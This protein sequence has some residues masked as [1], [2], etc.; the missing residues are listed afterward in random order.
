MFQTILLVHTGFIITRFI[1]SSLHIFLKVRINIPEI[2]NRRLHQKY[3]CG[4][5]WPLGGLPTRYTSIFTQLAL[6][7]C[8]L[9]HTY[10]STSVLTHPQSHTHTHM[11]NDSTYLRQH[12]TNCK[13]EKKH[14]PN[15]DIVR[16][17]NY[18]SQLRHNV[19]SFIYLQLPLVFKP[20]L[21]GPRENKK[22]MHY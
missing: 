13:E 12:S 9:Q 5:K 19:V 11:E 22:C 20:C 2:T 1:P 16:S 15:W 3:A 8:S 7:S 18:Q 14:F 21:L 6:G 17:C 4:M 10:I